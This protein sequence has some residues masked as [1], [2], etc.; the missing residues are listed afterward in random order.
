MQ[1]NC[2]HHVLQ[3]LILNRGFSKI[4]L[5]KF[6]RSH[7]VQISE[8][9]KASRH[10]IEHYFKPYQLDRMIRILKRMQQYDQ[11]LSFLMKAEKDEAE[12]SGEE[13]S[14]EVDV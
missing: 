9:L 5:A 11:A 4:E 8:A 6:I 10:E 7:S 2:L 13:E 14:D 1:E 3:E 12:E